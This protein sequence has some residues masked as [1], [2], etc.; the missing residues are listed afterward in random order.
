MNKIVRS[1]N[2]KIP[3]KILPAFTDVI[4]IIYLKYTFNKNRSILVKYKMIISILL[5]LSFCS[6]GGKV[7]VNWF[8]LNI[9]FEDELVPHVQN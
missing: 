4:G 5:A 1:T 2:V 7:E 8:C 9:F 3:E 6:C